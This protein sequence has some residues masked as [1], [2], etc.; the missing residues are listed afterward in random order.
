MITCNVCYTGVAC[1]F[2][3]QRSVNIACMELSFLRNRFFSVIES[4]TLSFERRQYGQL[5]LATAGLFVNIKLTF[6]TQGFE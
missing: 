6:L 4:R 3:E 5:F 1:S 2:Q